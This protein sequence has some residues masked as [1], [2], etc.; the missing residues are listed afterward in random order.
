MEP[1]RYKSKIDASQT[2]TLVGLILFPLGLVLMLVSAFALHSFSYADHPVAYSLVMVSYLMMLPHFMLSLWRFTNTRY[3][4]AD[5]TLR[6]KSGP[7]S[8]AVPLAEI[9][10]IKPVLN[11]HPSPALSFERLRIDH[12]EGKSL[13]ISPKLKEEF[14]QDL[15]ARRAKLRI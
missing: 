14:M 1:S 7:S 10:N 3:T 15:D 12:G 4:L 6:V 5:N 8:W 11:A 2:I 13:M 9:T